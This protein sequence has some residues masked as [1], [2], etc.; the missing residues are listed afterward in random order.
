MRSLRPEISARC[1]LSAAE[2][3]AGS[4]AVKPR[5]VVTASS[6]DRSKQVMAANYGPGIAKAK[7]FAV[8]LSTVPQARCEGPYEI[9]VRLYGYR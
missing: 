6:M 9:N 2:V 4:S 8:P 3:K 5:R 7:P 1:T